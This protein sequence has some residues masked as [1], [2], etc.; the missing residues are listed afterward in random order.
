MQGPFEVAEAADAAVTAGGRGRGTAPSGAAVAAV[1]G[2]VGL[3]AYSLE[4]RPPW[5]Q[6]LEPQP[7]Y[8]DFGTASSPVVHDGQ[9]LV[10]H[11]SLY[12]R[13]A[14]KLYRIKG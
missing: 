5:S 6:A 14:T 2:N 8:L 10:L 4:G 7:S 11:D 3:F 9:V 13:T 12:L 1:L